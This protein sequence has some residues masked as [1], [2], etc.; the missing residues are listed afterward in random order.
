M[1]M[2]L[3]C[4]SA[5]QLYEAF[6]RCFSRATTGHMAYPGYR[7]IAAVV[8]CGKTPHSLRQNSHCSVEESDTV[9]HPEVWKWEGIKAAMIRLDGGGEFAS[10]LENVNAKITPDYNKNLQDRRAAKA[11]ATAR[12]VTVDVLLPEE[13]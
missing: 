4:F 3:Q 7:T 9:L 8:V 12:P 2:E 10:I 5:Q 13:I 6:H 11:A 1:Y